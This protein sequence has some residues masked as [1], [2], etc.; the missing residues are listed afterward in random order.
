M[1]VAVVGDSTPLT[2]MIADVGAVLRRYGK[3]LDG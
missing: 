2:E 3:G 1:S